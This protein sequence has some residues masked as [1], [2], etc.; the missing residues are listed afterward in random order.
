MASATAFASW[1]YGKPVAAG[2]PL[3]AATGGL[4]L[5]GGAAVGG[6]AASA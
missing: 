6:G 2:A 3:G 5:A 4:P 1:P